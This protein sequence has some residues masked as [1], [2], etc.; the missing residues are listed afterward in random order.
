[1]VWSYIKENML[2]TYLDKTMMFKC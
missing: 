2:W 1:M